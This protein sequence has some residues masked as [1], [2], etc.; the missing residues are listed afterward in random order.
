MNIMGRRSIRE[1]K[2]IYQTCREAAALTREQ[3]SEQMEFITSDRIE[4][5]E[6]EKTTPQPDEI[7]AMAKCYKYPALCNYY[8]SHECSIGQKQVPEVAQKELTQITLE[9]LA[10]INSLTAAKDRL[11]EI[12]ADGKIERD[13]LTD[14]NRIKDQL[15]QMEESIRSLRLWIETTG[16]EES[17]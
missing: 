3:A 17:Q 11:I 4:K 7:L 6:Y 5:I 13:E 8:C 1:N 9:I 10:S 15:Q 16:L 14:F 2:T 12:S